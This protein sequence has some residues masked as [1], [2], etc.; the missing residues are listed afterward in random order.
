M[1]IKDERQRK[2]RRLLM[3][4][5]KKRVNEL[6]SELNRESVTTVQS[7][8]LRMTLGHLMV[9]PTRGRIKWK[10]NELKQ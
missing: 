4:I 3:F 9:D 1:M 7:D 2:I 8:T 5:S 10:T 6:R